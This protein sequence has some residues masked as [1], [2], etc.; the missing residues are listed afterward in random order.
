MACFMRMIVS[1]VTVFSKNFFNNEYCIVS[2]PETG[3]PCIEP[4]LDR[5]KCDRLNCVEMTTRSSLHFQ[6]NSPEFHLPP[7]VTRSASAG[8]AFSR[9]THFRPANR[10]SRMCGLTEI[11]QPLQTAILTRKRI[12]NRWKIQDWPELNSGFENEPA[13]CRIMRHANRTSL[14]AWGK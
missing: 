11:E 14:L 6:P 3:P 9:H 8:S 5:F 4:V 13:S 1:P 12:N 10:R 2:D 7:D